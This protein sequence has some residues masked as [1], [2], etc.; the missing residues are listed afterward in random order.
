MP[1][2]TPNGE[3][4]FIDLNGDPFAGGSVFSYV[5]GTTNPSPTYTDN[6][7]SVANPN[8]VVLDGAGRAV[9]WTDLI[10]R[11][12]V[13]DMF[14]NLVWDKPT[15]ISIDHIYGNLQVDGTLN[16]NGAASFQSNVNVAGSVAA[17]G[18][19]NVGGTTDLNVLNV[20]GN[21]TLN[22]L[23]TNGAYT[24][25]GPVTTNGSLTTNGALTANGTTVLNGTVTIPNGV[26]GNITAQ[27]GFC[28]VT[29]CI[30][31]LT[32]ANQYINMNGSIIIHG[33]SNA[34]NV[35]IL[36]TPDPQ[37]YTDFIGRGILIVSNDNPYI[38]LYNTFGPFLP[39]VMWGGTVAFNWGLSNANNGDPSAAGTTQL[40]SLDDAGNLTIIGTLT[41]GGAAMT[42]ADSAAMG[43][44]ALDLVLA[45]PV[46]TLPHLGIAE[47]DAPVMARAARGVGVNGDI[48]LAILWKAVQELSAKV[49]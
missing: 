24:A 38:A 8:P 31:I 36:E 10:T 3:Q 12:V 48:L 13:Y 32:Q 20:S 42:E 16:V 49:A 22:T 40:M 43:D 18:N 6:S 11:Q 39:W 21:T 30:D 47:S 9:M 15:G 25:N 27:P 17:S 29:D 45:S 37:S 44:G 5:P 33:S 14:G 4:Q 7:M 34:P 1:F 28:V 46:K 23:T 2:P 35:M 26:A 19:L 41:Q